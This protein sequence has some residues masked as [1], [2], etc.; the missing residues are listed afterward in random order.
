MV[1]KV[2]ENSRS[3]RLIDEAVLQMF[4]SSYKNSLCSLGGSTAELVK[5][6]FGVSADISKQISENC[7]QENPRLGNLERPHKASKT[8]HIAVSENPTPFQS[9][10]GT[11]NNSIIFVD[12]KTSREEFYARIFHELYISYDSFLFL[13]GNNTADI[14][15]FFKIKSSS[16]ESYSTAIDALGYPLLRM[17][18]A[19]IRGVQFEA[20]VVSE[21]FG[22]QATM[23]LESYPL[24]TL[25]QQNEY[26]KAAL[27]VSDSLL[28]LQSFILPFNYLIEK[29]DERMS[30][31]SSLY[32]NEQEA[33]QLVKRMETSGAS[34]NVS[35]RRYSLLELLSKPA[36]GPHGQFF[37]SGPRPRIG[38]GWAKEQQSSILINDRNLPAQWNLD[39]APL[40]QPKPNIKIPKNDIKEATLNNL[41]PSFE[42]TEVHP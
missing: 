30:L 31:F 29:Y 36:L 23:K 22:L 5:I 6:S 17:T 26:A 4:T 20:Q 14:F 21:I 8:W 39:Q 28:P 16:K 24:I 7:R 34:F 11:F 38:G 3:Q 42:R 37:T 41:K 27:L 1:Y 25:L 33:H 9:W 40:M 10:T 32:L 12:G 35:S 19:S 18:F 13:G 15:D 2:A